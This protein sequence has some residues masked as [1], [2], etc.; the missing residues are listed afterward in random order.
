MIY[1]EIFFLLVSNHDQLV[2]NICSGPATSIC[3]FSERPL[4][5]KINL[6]INF[7]PS[8]VFKHFHNCHLFCIDVKEW[9]VLI[10][11]SILFFP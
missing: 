2:F 4:V 1:A 5:S 6:F 10:L 8:F 9:C 7:W 3:S 11:S